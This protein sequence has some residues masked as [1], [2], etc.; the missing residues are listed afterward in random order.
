MNRVEL[1]TL[2]MTNLGD[3]KKVN[4]SG[5][6]TIFVHEDLELEK[7]DEKIVKDFCNLCYSML[8][9]TGEYECYLCDNRKDSKIKTTAICAF[10][11]SNI[12]IYCKNRSLADILR[13]IG[14]EM[15]HL[16]Q[17]EMDLVPVKQGPHHLSP[18]EWHA[19]IAGGALLSYFA[20]ELGKD[21][22]YR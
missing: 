1:V 6:F 3:K 5:D 4:R 11:E 10:G 19:N 13:S 8:E 2:L 22:I 15:F 18:V 20:N 12:R 9:L 17:C 14:H 7:A 21:K 16:R